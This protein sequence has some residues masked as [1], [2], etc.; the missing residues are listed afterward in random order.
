MSH[1]TVTVVTKEKPNRKT[2][3]DALAPFHE[4]GCTGIDDQYVQDIDVFDEHLKYYEREIKNYESF[5]DYI[6]QNY[7]MEV[8]Q[9]D[10]SPDTAGR[11]KYGWYR[12]KDGDVVEVVS[13]TNP[14]S[15]WDWWEIGGRWTNFYLL[16]DGSYAD[17]ARKSDIDVEQM[18]NDAGDDAGRR[19]DK[20]H[21]VVGEH[22]ASYTKWSDLLQTYRNRIEK[23][24]EVYA[25]QPAVEALEASVIEDKYFINLDVFAVTR[26]DFVEN[27]RRNALRTFAF[28]CDGEWKEEGM[29]GWFAIVS[30]E[31]VNWQQDFAKLFDNIP[32]DHYVTVVD[33]HT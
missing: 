7:G 10:E 31:N 24:R 20:V 2:I 14:N 15:K 28:L 8:V 30:N 17:C 33:C 32:D 26:E 18:R 29:M 9:G 12:V 27:A 13:R 3:E 16:K 6:E 11:H 5:A 1:F 21:E 22:M 4:F 23:A 19:W 25:S